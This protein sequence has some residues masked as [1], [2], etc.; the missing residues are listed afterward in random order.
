MLNKG[1][2]FS[3][4]V[5]FNSHFIE[6]IIKTVMQWFSVVSKMKLV[7]TVSHVLVTSYHNVTFTIAILLLYEYKYK[8]L[9]IP[10]IFAK[11]CEIVIDPRLKTTAI[12]P[13]KQQT[14]IYYSKELLMGLL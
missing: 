9:C 14:E 2:S 13:G 5:H 4:W 6:G 7:N 3:V 12:I 10:M 8:Y 11:P 1:M